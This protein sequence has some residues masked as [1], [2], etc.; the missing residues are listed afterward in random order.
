M[1]IFAEELNATAPSEETLVFLPGGGVSGWSW[2]AVGERLPEYRSLLVDLPGHGRSR[3]AG[4]FS[5]QFAAAEVESLIKERAGGS[6]H[7]VGLSLGAQVAI[8]LLATNAA[9]VQSAFV[10]GCLT[11]PIPGLGNYHLLKAT[12]SLYAP[13]QNMPWLVRANARSSGVPREYEEEFAADTRSLTPEMLASVIA[14]NQSFRLPIGLHGV[15]TPTLVVVG[16][17][18]LGPV[19]RSARDLRDS[20]VRARAYEVVGRQ[21]SWPISDAAL[22]AEGIRAFLQGTTLPEQF[23]P[24]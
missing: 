8:Q 7:V 22:C 9:A 3:D 16:E 10:S 15:S 5:M 1:G 4:R 19:K 13:F 21:H 24:M 2:R 6:A 12:F 18:E 11:R 20:L 17:K 14:A 23:R